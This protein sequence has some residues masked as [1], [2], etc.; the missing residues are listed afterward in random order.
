MGLCQDLLR[1]T[2]SHQMALCSM[3][4]ELHDLMKRWHAAQRYRRIQYSRQMLRLQ[5][6]HGSACRGRSA[7]IHTGRGS[8]LLL[9]LQQAPHLLQNQTASSLRG[10]VEARVQE[11]E[12][13]V[14]DS[15]SGSESRQD[16][17]LAAERR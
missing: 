10:C 4:M 8:Y 2:G 13:R 7:H 17:V 5:R 6:E 14:Q 15:F 9:A 1:G 12:F 3:C 11:P 16:L